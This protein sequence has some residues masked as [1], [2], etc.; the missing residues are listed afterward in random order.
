[1]KKSN[2]L[3]SVLATSAMVGLPLVIVNINSQNQTNIKNANF[4]NNK[5]E[6]KTLKNAEQIIVSN[7]NIMKDSNFAQVRDLMESIVMTQEIL[8]KLDIVMPNQSDPAKVSFTNIKNE[9]FKISF[10]IN[11]NGFPKTTSDFLNITPESQE[12]ANHIYVED[13]DALIHN[14]PIVI[15]KLLET[16]IMTQAILNQAKIIIPR[17]AEASKVS[18]S[19]IN[20]DNPLRV[21]FHINYNGVE[22]I[23]PDFLNATATDLEVA[24]AIKLHNPDILKSLDVISIRNILEQSPMSIEILEQLSITI[25]EGT[26]AALVSF[27]E[28]N[29][30]NP[31]IITFNINYNGTPKTSSDF[32]NATLT[33]KQTAEKTIIQNPNILGNQNINNI[34]GLL[35]ASPMTR[36]ILEQLSFKIPQG[37]EPSKYLFT[38]IDTTNPFKITFLLKYN[39]VAKSSPDS[40]NAKPTDKETVE[41]IAVQNPDILKSKNVSYIKSLLDTPVMTKEVLAELSIFIPEGG[42]ISKLSFT[43]IDMSGLYGVSFR[44]NYNRVSKDVLDFLS[45][46]PS[47]KDVAEATTLSNPNIIKQETVNF[48]KNILESPTMTQD[49]LTQLSIQI[50]LGSTPELFSFTKIDITNPFKISFVINY[51]GVAKDSIEFLNATP[52][53][54]EI[55][56]TIFIKDNGI[57]KTQKVL[58]I[59]DILETKVITTEILKS[60]SITLP[61][62]V[63]PSLVTFTDVNVD[64]PLRV[65]FIINYNRVPKGTPDFLLAQASEAEIVDSITIANVDSLKELSGIKIRNLLEASPMTQENLDKLGITFPVGADIRKLAFNKINITNLFKVTFTISYNSVVKKTS[66]FLTSTPTNLEVANKIHIKNTNILKSQDALFIKGLLEGPVT[67]DSLNKLSVLFPEGTDIS[68]ITFTEINITNPLRVT[69][70]INYNGIAKSSQN[71]LN[72]TPSD[73]DVVNSIILT[74]SNSVSNLGVERI[75]SLLETKPMSQAILSKLTI[76]VPAG[77]EIFRISFNNIVITNLFKVT[78]TI[79]YN[80]IEKS[81]TDFLNSTPLNQDIANTSL[82]SDRNIL[83]NKDVSFIKRLLDTKPMSLAVLN[84][85]SI[86]IPSGSSPELITFT[87]V[88]ITNPLRITFVINYNGIPKET[89][90]Y[91][92]A[93]A[94]DLEVVNVIFVKDKDAARLENSKFVKELL[95]KN[96]TTKEILAQLSINVPE[97]ADIS[98]ISFTDINIENPLRVIFTISYNNV[99]KPTPDLLNVTPAQDIANA[100]MVENVDILQTENA[101]YIKGLLE[102]NPMSQKVLDELS[103]KLPKGVD[104]ARIT[105]TNIDTSN[106]FRITFKINYNGVASE[107]ETFFNT[108]PKDKDIANAII[109]QDFDIFKDQELLFVQTLLETSPMTTE[110]LEQLSIIVPTGIDVTKITFTDIDVSNLALI[111]FK[112]NYNGVTGDKAFSFNIRAP[113]SSTILVVSTV[114]PISIILIVGALATAFII[115]KRNGGTFENV[116]RKT[117]KNDESQDQLDNSAKSIK[118]IE[119]KNKYQEYTKESNFGFNNDNQGQ[120]L[121]PNQSQDNGQYTND[122]YDENGQYQNQD[123]YYDNQDGYYDQYDENGN[124]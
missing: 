87:D 39:G 88:N 113:Y 6:F 41:S 50:P 21:S 10:T 80:G 81:T 14:E 30:T 85:L 26:N 82:V 19:K 57:M 102:T 51:N 101:L 29:I 117:P 68:L 54:A 55:S 49:I 99:P 104:P 109:I 115:R 3:K 72:S 91:L 7:P 36:E 93:L 73:L 84:Q 97:G 77:T 116:F 34:K 5:P 60:L 123:G 32:L 106:L 103:I 27:T 112:V 8:N 124:Q 53:D 58:T 48:I 37:A 120:V 35:E 20:I 76:K 121:Y 18:F 23:A 74:D 28:V 56:R 45:A 75:R 47:D 44:I 12:V 62:G 65:T 11:Y 33:D 90:D 69:F 111:S 70:T 42:D 100:I 24:T 64:N 38:E 15:K 114:V 66:D 83:V 67:L 31:F 108:S 61:D 110:V 98:K 46:T 119:N 122:Q 105:M 86:T 16:P 92:K 96:P 118:P 63:N 43:N 89:P 79:T 94:T 107:R 22:K 13:I 17:D 1:M 52:T 25:P 95:D 4:K 78:F 40:L 59:R 9:L 71:F 2:I